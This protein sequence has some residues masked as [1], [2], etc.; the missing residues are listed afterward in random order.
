MVDYTV[1][2]KEPAILCGD[3]NF[4]NRYSFYRLTAY[5][6]DDSRTLAP[7]SIT[8]ASY[9]AYHKIFLK[10][11]GHGYPLDHIFLQ[12]DKFTVHS[13]EVLNYL[14]DGKFSSDHFPVVAK[15]S[16]ND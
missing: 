8:T 16:I 1:N 13:Y 6:L 7:D 10:T 9:N 12:K 11:G 15:I 4:D 2:S 5:K 3:F 14:I